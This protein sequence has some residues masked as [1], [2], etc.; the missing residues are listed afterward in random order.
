MI[1]IIMYMFLNNENIYA[2]FKK[3]TLCVEVGKYDK[4]RKCTFTSSD[5]GR[6]SSND[7]F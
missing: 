3:L 5:S 7:P 6:K 2:F 1:L 4:E